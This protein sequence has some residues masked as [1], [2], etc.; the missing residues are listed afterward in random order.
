M[1]NFCRENPE[2]SGIEST[3]AKEIAGPDK[4]RGRH[5]SIK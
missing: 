2:L 3:E 5:V 1:R 4:S